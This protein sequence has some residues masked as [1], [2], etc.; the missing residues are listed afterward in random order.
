M[1]DDFD[2]LS[3]WHESGDGLYFPPVKRKARR[4]AKEERDPLDPLLLEAMAEV[5][6]MVPNTP[7]LTTE[8]RRRLTKGL[9]TDEE[10]E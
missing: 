5:D 10:K 6:E 2:L 8:D 3:S 1:S 7:W 4:Y 9:H